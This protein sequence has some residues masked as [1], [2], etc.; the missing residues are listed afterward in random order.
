MIFLF[1]ICSTREPSRRELYFVC[2]R[3][4][5][6]VCVLR[7]AYK[8]IEEPQGFPP[9]VTFSRLQPHNNLSVFISHAR[10]HA[11]WGGNLSHCN[12]LMKYTV[13]RYNSY[14]CGLINWDKTEEGA[15][16]D[17]K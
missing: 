1:L 3:V 9:F 16:T 12:T 14:L 13:V 10:T 5:V 8:C 17:I 11:H 2:V 15:M 4:C 7:Q 6:S